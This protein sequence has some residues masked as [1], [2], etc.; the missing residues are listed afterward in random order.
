MVGL[1]ICVWPFILKATAVAEE[2]SEGDMETFLRI[3]APR[4]SGTNAVHDL[5]THFIPWGFITLMS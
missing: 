5:S 2:L 1:T 3:I 4:T